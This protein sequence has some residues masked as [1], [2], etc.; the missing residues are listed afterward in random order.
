LN[1]N[2][3]L[4]KFNQAL[5]ISGIY[6]TSFTP[7]TINIFD[8]KALVTISVIIMLI[9]GYFNLGVNDCNFFLIRETSEGVV[10]EK[11]KLYEDEI[12][13][14][15]DPSIIS[16]VMVF[17]PGS[18]SG[19]LVMAGDKLKSI[20]AGL[21]GS[22]IKITISYSD[23]EKKEMPPINVEKA[24]SL[25][26]RIN[27]SGFKGYKVAYR[28]ENYEDIILD[29]GPVIDMFAGHIPLNE[30][31]FSL[32]T[33][34]HEAKPKNLLSGRADLEIVR[35]WM[36]VIGRL[37]GG[38]EGKFI[39]D[40]GASSTII[41]SKIIDEQYEVRPFRMVEHSAEGSKESDAIIG[42]ATGT[43]D[44]IQGITTLP[45]F[46][47]G[48]ISCKDQD[49]TVLKGFPDG[50]SKHGI[51]GIIGRDILERA[52][53]L[54]ISGL[55]NG[56]DA[57]IE[58]AEP[59]TVNNNSDHQL[60]YHRAG[61][62]FFVNGKIQNAPISFLIDTGSGKLIIDKAFLEENNIQYE[63]DNGKSRVVTGLDGKG[64]NI[65]TV[66][67]ENI[68]VGGIELSEFEFDLAD[69]YIFERMGLENETALLGMEFFNDYG[70]VVIDFAEEQI[71][72][73]N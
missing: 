72:L 68:N 19:E 41:D 30:G 37:P 54:K 62:H 26:S 34:T 24:Q 48:N 14:F 5:T 66:Q 27:I 25:N 23:G 36:V 71:L 4:T 7:E 29:H 3:T 59:S 40:I 10:I 42:G 6:S 20:S 69:L 49:V 58:F 61:G 55:N 63:K 60:N 46:S 38:I 65:S 47:F 2:L 39:I 50:I 44:N 31:D 16:Y 32:L 17:N 51:S 15:N 52:G 33:E 70:T 21:Y 1:I 56:T 9:S 64:I 35:N 13:V 22:E 8:M 28:I 57:S 12:T 45:D 73:W 11:V 18:K 67:I 43:V 53:A